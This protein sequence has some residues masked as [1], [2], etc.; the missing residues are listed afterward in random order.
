M[1]PPW[2]FFLDVS[3]IDPVIGRQREEEGS[4]DEG[5]S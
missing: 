3:Q 4:I 5:V 2:S 1:V